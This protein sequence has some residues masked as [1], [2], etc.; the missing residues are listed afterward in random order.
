MTVTVGTD[1][2]LSV[3]DT[4]AYWSARNNSTWQSADNADKEKALIEATQYIDGAYSFIGTQKID[5]VLAW[6]RFDVYITK[7]N[8][9]GQSY[10]SDT[11]PPQIK[12][13]CAELALEALAARLSPVKD[14]GGMIKRE[15]VD[16]IEVE[17]LDWAPTGKTFN[18]VSMLI[19][20]LTKGS[21]S[22]KGLVRT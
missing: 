2:Y 7:G 3:A 11:I 14:R 6:P 20:P 18:F 16:V 22:M 15:K 13:A 10:D 1:V 21:K 12:N 19:K 4:D 5:N 17:Y 9:A 8:F